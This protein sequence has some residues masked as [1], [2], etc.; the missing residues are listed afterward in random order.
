MET[1]LL[2]TT[3]VRELLNKH[4]YLLHTFINMGLRCV[5]CPTDAF[6]TLADVADEY[7]FE[8]DNFISRLQNAVDLIET[9]ENAI[10]QLPDERE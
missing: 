8:Q 4:P 6:H 7:G 5:G 1:V 3:T 9:S 2:E 10:F